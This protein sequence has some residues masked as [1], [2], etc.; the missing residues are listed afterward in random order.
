MSV[1]ARP[2]GRSGSDAAVVARPALTDRV[3]TAVPLAST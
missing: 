3:L 2:G 1:L